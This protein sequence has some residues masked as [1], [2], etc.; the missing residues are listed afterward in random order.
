MQRLDDELEHY[1]KMLGF[2]LVYLEHGRKVPK[3]HGWQNNPIS[4]LEEALKVWMHGGNV[5][6]HHAASGTA[7]LDIDHLK[8]TIRALA[9]VDI[10]LGALLA[11]PGPKI[12]SAKGLK[13]IYRLPEGTELKRKVLTW[14]EPGALKATTVFELRAGNVQD[15]LPPSIH[16]D[17]RMPYIWE[18]A[19]PESRDEIPVLPS[20]LLALWENW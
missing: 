2:S 12:R 1:I 8:W 6:I 17:T 18:P 20:G 14:H 9:T 5:G 10:D 3:S 7:I 13:P 16:P 4:N 15:V 19:R 11:E